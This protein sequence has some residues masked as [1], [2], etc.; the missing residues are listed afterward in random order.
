MDGLSPSLA[1]PVV[2][3][4]ARWIFSPRASWPKSRRRLE[5]GTALPAPPRGTAVTPMTIGGVRCEEI[6][7]PRVVGAG[8]MLYLHGGGYTGGSPRTHRTLVAHIAAAT[9]VRAVVPDY[10]LAPENPYPAAVEDAV[11]ACAGILESGTAPEQLVVAGDSAGGGLALAVALRRRERG[12][13]LPAVLGLVCPWLDLASAARARRGPAPKEPILT[14]GL[15][16]RFARAY[17]AAGDPCDPL[18]SPLQG[19]LRG[20]PPLVIHVGADDLIAS[21][22][23]ELATRARAAGV[24]VTERRYPGLWHDFHIYVGVVAGAARAVNE[25]GGA[26]RTSITQGAGAPC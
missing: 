2:H 1:R 4:A 16:A 25:L 18:I 23:I 15:L 14:E 7:P 13:P 21:D 8:A 20:L 24:T 5:L 17:I 9:C 26:L 19:D 3:L 22:G 6:V 10:R 11:T 12:E